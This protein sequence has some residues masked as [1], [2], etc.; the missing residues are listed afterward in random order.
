MITEIRLENFKSFKELTKIPLKKINVFIGPNGA[1]KSTPLQ[2]LMLLKQ[3]RRH[4][5]LVTRG[6]FANLGTVS[7]LIH[8]PG[9]ALG[10]GVTVT[11]SLRWDY[12][13]FTKFN[14]EGHVAF[15]QRVLK[16]GSALTLAGKTVIRV[17]NP[18]LV[19]W[20]FSVQTGAQWE[21]GHDFKDVGS[22]LVF[23]AEIGI[24]NGF[25]S[26]LT[27]MNTLLT[28]LTNQVAE[29]QLVPAS[30][31]IEE[32]ML[33]VSQRRRKEFVLA[34]TP[35][36]RSRELATTLTM[37]RETEEQ[38]SSWFDSITGIH[39]QGRLEEDQQVSIQSVGKHGRVNIVNEGFGS[40]QLV[41]LLMQYASCSAGAFIAIE[42]PEA[43]LHPKAQG[44]LTKI[45]LERAKE[46][47]LQ[48]VLITHS[49]HV[50]HALL[51]KVASQELTP[52]DLGILYFQREES[53]SHVKALEVTNRGQVKGGLPGFFEAELD[54]FSEFVQALSKRQ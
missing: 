37:S 17:S 13:D 40:N 54:Q 11:N 12:K 49:E 48:L 35:H 29:C 18:D 41:H 53:V 34:H 38:I 8:P 25:T 45:L 3:S 22:Q 52:E 2:A 32:P 50:L 24:L 23:G 10:L 51:N 44:T 46:H 21:S 20:Q 5:V 39:L 6:E 30:R 16:I 4:D 14:K 27:D 36:E 33:P 26:N 19:S 42:E 7:E 1:G 15:I 9:D 43:H 47:D 28:E 31:G